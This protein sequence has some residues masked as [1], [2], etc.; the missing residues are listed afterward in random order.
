MKPTEV[1]PRGPA[2]LAASMSTPVTPSAIDRVGMVEEQ[3]AGVDLARQR[4]EG[5]AEEGIGAAARRSVAR[6]IA[7]ISSSWSRK[8]AGGVEHL[9]GA[10]DRAARRARARARLISGCRLQ[11]RAHCLDRV[12]ASASARRGRRARRRGRRP[13]SSAHR[14]PLECRSAKKKRRRR[15]APP[16]LHRVYDLRA[17]MRMA[18]RRRRG[19]AVHRLPSASASRA[20][21]RWCSAPEWL[22]I[23]IFLFIDN[24]P[25]M[26]VPDN[27]G[28]VWAPSVRPKTAGRFFASHSRPESHVPGLSEGPVRDGAHTFPDLIVPAVRRNMSHGE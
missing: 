3:Q 4:M 15:D 25:L 24:S 10:S 27:G 9:L 1:A 7:A 16:P 5:R 2:F 21:R 13:R 28:K 6:I 11:S 26:P 17:R 23:S 22:A 14:F 12:V 18:T 19:R 20:C 8:R